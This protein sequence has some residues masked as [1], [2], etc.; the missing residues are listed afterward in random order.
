MTEHTAP[1]SKVLVFGIGNEL[2][3]DDRLG[4]ECVTILQR[5]LSSSEEVRCMKSPQLTLEDAELFARYKTVIIVDATM[6]DIG[7][8]SF[9]G[10]D[11]DRHATFTTHLFSAGQLEMIARDLFG[12]DPDLY[13]LHI[14]GYAWDCS[15]ALSPRAAD[16]LKKALA[17]LT[18]ALR[19][20]Q[21]ILRHQWEGMVTHDDE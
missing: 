8:F 18:R 9:S 14:K 5:I 1:G 7:A 12:G 17:F 16:N 20:P 13:L 10:A 3:A 6:E 4:L 21:R 15:E 11:M 19:S 2:R